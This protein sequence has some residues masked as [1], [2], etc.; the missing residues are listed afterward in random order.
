MSPLPIHKQKNGA[1][2]GGAPGRDKSTDATQLQRSV[3]SLGRGAD[4]DRV[5]A[6]RSIPNDNP[7]RQVRGPSNH[8]NRRGGDPSELRDPIVDVCA[9]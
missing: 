7:E 4:V 9:R 2:S 3:S 8:S 1:Q 5:A 6:I